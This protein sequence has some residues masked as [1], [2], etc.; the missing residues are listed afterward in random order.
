MGVDVEVDN[1]VDDDN[2]NVD[3]NDDVSLCFCHINNILRMAMFV[4]HAL[5]AEELHLVRFDESAM[6]SW[7]KA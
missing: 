3:H 4:P 2:F 5:V 6:T 1:A 7:L